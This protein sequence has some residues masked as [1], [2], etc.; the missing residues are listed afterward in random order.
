[1]K[2]DKG[3]TESESIKDDLVRLW[4]A[5]SGGV[6]RTTDRIERGVVKALQ[7]IGLNKLC[8]EEIEKIYHL[9]EKMD[10]RQKNIA[11][12]ELRAKSAFASTYKSNADIE[13]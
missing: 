6:E 2:K 9:A 5:A 3:V 8:V 11:Q 12:A 10:A 4:N 13:D 7:A 1:M